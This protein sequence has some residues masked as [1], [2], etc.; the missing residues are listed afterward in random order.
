MFLKYKKVYN[1]RMNSE[2]S[3]TPNSE[4]E[5]KEEQQQFTLQRYTEFLKMIG[6]RDLTHNSYTKVANYPYFT[7]KG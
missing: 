1:Y 7:Y 5:A 3:T 6:H 2:K 4:Q